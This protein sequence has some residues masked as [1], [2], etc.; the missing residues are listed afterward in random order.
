MGQL[1]DNLASTQINL[2]AEEVDRIGETTEPKSIYPQW[3][4]ERM[5]D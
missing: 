1:E 4:V 3:M 2:T 5:N